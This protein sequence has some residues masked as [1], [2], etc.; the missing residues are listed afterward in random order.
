MNPTDNQNPNIPQ[1]HG[2]PLQVAPVP[3][4]QAF[5][6]Q[7]NT[8][9][10]AQ[11]PQATQ[12]NPGLP[13]D[14]S[15]P[16]ASQA[17]SQSFGQPIASQPSP[18]QPVQQ[19]TPQP[20]SQPL[21]TT[22]QNRFSPN[23]ASPVQSI[24]NAATTPQTT[25]ANYPQTTPA[26]NS[27]VTEFPGQ[28]IT[29]NTTNTTANPNPT[30]QG[31]PGVA[32]GSN[33]SPLVTL[34]AQLTFGGKPDSDAPKTPTMKVIG[35][36]IIVISILL[37]GGI[38]FA[39]VHVQ[40]ARAN[41]KEK[42]GT[43]R[44]SKKSD[45]DKAIKASGPDMQPLS[46]GN[47]LDVSKLF[48]QTLGAHKQDIKG[49]LNKQINMSN[50]V[51]FAVTSVEKNWPSTSSYTKPAPGNEF[52]KVDVMA[53]YRGSSE[54]GRFYSTSL[55]LKNSTGEMQDSR[56]VSSYGSAKQNGLDSSSSLNPGDT[57][58][59]WIVFEIKKNETPLTL[60]YS[61]TF[62][63]SNFKEQ[64]MKVSIEVK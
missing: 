46:E 61:S 19:N 26:N 48:N 2:E 33:K 44:N 30:A 53:G 8:Y 11:V 4:N 31:Q 39:T 35:I 16:V 1:V 17:Q 41:L 57:I 45:V 40:Q 20:V 12:I 50:G 9:Q 22:L 56:Y 62:Y 3:V 6:A 42:Y 58:S 52:M 18:I 5:P 47:K 28:N 38:V 54:T 7:E 36:V 23:A 63:D 60:V 27:L 43:A 59:G 37:S 24:P 64:T 55:R 32:D 13:L 49:E 15:L 25:E 29:Q 10:P 14:N 21:D 34:A 51:S